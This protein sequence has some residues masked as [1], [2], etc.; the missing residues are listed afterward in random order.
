MFAVVSGEIIGILTNTDPEIVRSESNIF[1]LVYVVAGIVIGTVTFLQV[2]TF[3]IAG[4]RLTRRL[5]ENA[6]L[7]MLRMEIAWF[8]DKRH[9]TGTLCS[10]LSA[11]A[12]AVQGATG[13][14]IGTVVSSLSTAV[15]SIGIGV[16]Y[17]W[18]L[19][20]VSLAFTPLII[21][22]HYYEIRL[23]NE[24]NLGNFK[25][26]EKSTKIAVEVVSNI[27]TVVSLGGERMFNAQYVGHLVPSLQAAQRLT[28]VRGIVYGLARSLMSFANA[29]CIAYGASLVVNEGMNISAV[30]V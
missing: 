11:D 30:F 5:R 13:Q 24:T 12:A 6:F 1:V 29:A 2:W 3:G 28:H 18:R 21:L 17:N 25:A 20:L 9:G 19:G 10:R 15:L 14:R 7:A 23:T 8:D 22:A 27:R 4:E 16:Y 26:L